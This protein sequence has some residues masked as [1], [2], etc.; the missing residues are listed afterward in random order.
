M[1]DHR[2]LNDLSH[3][4]CMGSTL[5]AGCCSTFCSRADSLTPTARRALLR[6]MLLR[7]PFPLSSSACC[8]SDK[9]L[10]LLPPPLLPLV[11]AAAVMWVSS[12]ARLSKLARVLAALDF[13][14]CTPCTRRWR[15][16]KQ[17]AAGAAGQ[18]CVSNRGDAGRKA[19]HTPCCCQSML[20]PTFLFPPPEKMDHAHLWAFGCWLRQNLLIKLDR[21]CDFA[22]QV[23]WGLGAV[24]LLL[25]FVLQA[26]AAAAAANPCSCLVAVGA[27]H[28]LLDHLEKQL[29]RSLLRLVYT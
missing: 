4:T 22:L 12:A 25:L 21:L 29:T 27:S 6:L 3:R 17:T 23:A 1:H 20:L 13:F 26:A 28:S 9:L 24:L 19:C 18:A 5:Y 8:C 11:A 10:P 14:F 15:E 7:V 2:R 16:D